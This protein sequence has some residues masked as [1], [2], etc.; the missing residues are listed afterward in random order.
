MLLNSD[1]ILSIAFGIEPLELQRLLLSCNA[2]KFP[3]S[4]HVPY[5]KLLACK[6]RMF[7]PSCPG[8]VW[9]LC[10]LGRAT[11][12]L[13][14]KASFVRLQKEHKFKRQVNIHLKAFDARRING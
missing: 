9:P 4:F 12:Q 1:S 3:F 10:C 6:A 8:A 2:T 7:L 13:Y 11:A 14:K 5:V